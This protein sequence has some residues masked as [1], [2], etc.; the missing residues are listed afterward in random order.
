MQTYLD[1]KYYACDANLCRSNEINKNPKSKHYILLILLVAKVL[2]KVNIMIIGRSRH[3]LSSNDRNESNQM[4]DKLLYCPAAVSHKAHN[5]N[6]ALHSRQ[7]V[8]N[9]TVDI[10]ESKVT[11]ILRNGCFFLR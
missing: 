1:E 8:P 3:I 10:A 9:E 5:C 2:N 11:S 7:V 4:F 6:I